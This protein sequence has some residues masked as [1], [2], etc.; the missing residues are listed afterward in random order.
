TRVSITGDGFT[1]EHW[2]TPGV[3]LWLA[4]GPSD[5]DFYAPAD[6]DV[7][8]SADGHL[9]GSFAVPDHGDCRQSS[10]SLPIEAGTYRIVYQCTAC[11]IG[12]FDVT[13]SGVPANAECND[14]AFSPNSDNLASSIRTYGP[15]CEEAD[16]VV[17]EV[18]GPFGPINGAA[19]GEA[20]G[21]TCVRTGQE[22]AGLPSA[23]HECTRGGQR[24][25][26]VRT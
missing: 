6:H 26:F 12:E 9:S 8:V 10:T 24:I 20:G 25:T 2:Q 1:D 14:V 18:G 4:G 16:A 15:S 11:I 23:T 22:D 7:Q 3:P 5:C 21:F 17:R 19:R 13:A